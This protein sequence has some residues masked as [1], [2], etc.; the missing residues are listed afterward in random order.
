MSQTITVSDDLYARLEQSARHRGF[1]SVEQLVDAWQTAEDKL[2]QRRAAVQRIHETRE[3]LRSAYGEL[4][5]ST[6]WIREDRAR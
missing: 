6:E 5:D 4:P 3:K 2:C 1:A